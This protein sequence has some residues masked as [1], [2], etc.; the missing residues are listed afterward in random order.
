MVPGGVARHQVQQHVHA[1]PVG[2]GEQ[3]LQILVGAVARGHGVIVGHVVACVSEGRI[4]AGIQPQG[5]AAQVKN[6][7]Q[8]FRDA[9][10]VADAVGVGVPEGLGIDLIKNRVVKPLWHK[11]LSLL[12][13]VC[14]T[15][16]QL[17]KTSCNGKFYGMLT[18]IHQQT[19]KL[20][21]VER[22]DN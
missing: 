3:P 7:V 13:Q 6:I 18:G 4:K 20:G 16:I 15:M 1:P 14:E 22:I 10:Q 19:G 17:E 12:F 11:S 9:V 5:V 2:L 21:F 8:L